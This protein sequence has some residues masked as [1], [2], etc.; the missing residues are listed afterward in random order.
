M[1]ADT[2]GIA[3]S[4][5]DDRS[6][7]AALRM[8][9]KVRPPASRG[10]CPFGPPPAGPFIPK[11]RQMRNTK[12]RPSGPRSGWLPRQHALLRALHRERA[13]RALRVERAAVLAT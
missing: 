11:A 7:Q 1:Q 8:G 13:G 6:G 4:L 9:A 3:P 5:H 12:K 2:F 10:E